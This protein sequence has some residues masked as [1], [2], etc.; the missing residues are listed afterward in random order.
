MVRLTTSWL[1]VTPR[2]DLEWMGLELTQLYQNNG[3]RYKNVFVHLS[4]CFFAC[5]F[6][7]LYHIFLNELLDCFNVLKLWSERNNQIL[8]SLDDVHWWY[9]I[10]PHF[11][12]RIARD[13]ECKKTATL[14]RFARKMWNDKKMWH[15]R[16]RSWLNQRSAPHRQFY[17]PGLVK[18]RWT[19]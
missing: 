15:M 18:L 5:V 7:F 10:S 13:D 6:T 4:V 3:L 9:L 12:W 17:W 14:S 1:D 19:T 16:S 2:Y 11:E 8:L